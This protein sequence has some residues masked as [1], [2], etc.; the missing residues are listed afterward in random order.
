MSAPDSILQLV[1]NFETHRR[2]YLSQDFNETLT[3]TGK[4]LL[5]CQIESTDARIDTLVYELYGLMEEE[6]RLVEGK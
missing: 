2:A 1:E 4:S 6:I 5:Q 3:P